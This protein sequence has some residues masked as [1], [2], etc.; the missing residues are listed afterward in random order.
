MRTGREKFDPY[1][2]SFVGG[3]TQIH[4]AALLLFFRHRID[5]DELDANFQFPLEVKQA[6][7][8]VD[9]NRLAVLAEFPPSGVLADR[10][11]G[12]ARKDSRTAPFSGDFRVHA[13]IVL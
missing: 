9:D 4:D 2:S 3:V 10:A 7:M 13:D 5:E 11:H 1:T 12:D 8:S 6:A